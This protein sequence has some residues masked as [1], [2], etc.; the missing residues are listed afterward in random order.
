MH[1]ERPLPSPRERLGITASDSVKSVQKVAK[2]GRVAAEAGADYSFAQRLAETAP[3]DF[4]AE[5]V[6]TA[7]RLGFDHQFIALAHASTLSLTQVEFD[8]SYLNQRPRGIHCNY[9]KNI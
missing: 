2:S 5:G 8:E 4:Q 9:S 6:A 1:P 7:P 3:L